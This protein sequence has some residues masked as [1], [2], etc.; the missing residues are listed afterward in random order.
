MSAQA[1]PW[2]SADLHSILFQASF[3][4]TVRC[5]WSGVRCEGSQPIESLY[6]LIVR[7]MVGWPPRQAAMVA[8]SSS[9]WGRYSAAE[10]AAHRAFT[11][12]QP[13]RAPVVSSTVVPQKP[14]RLSSKLLFATPT[15]IASALLRG[16]LNE[17]S[18]SSRSIGSVSE[19]CWD[20]FDVMT[21]LPVPF[22]RASA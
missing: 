1:K 18:N 9:Y 5:S 12:D 11:F 8:N 20:R 3:M 7:R 17:D 4:M 14:S 22:A 6:L 16:T 10:A 2:R 21:S 13:L 15:M 19:L